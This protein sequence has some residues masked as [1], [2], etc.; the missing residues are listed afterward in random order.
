MKNLTPQSIDRLGGLARAKKLSAKQ[1]S[2]RL[3]AKA[4]GSR[5]SNNGYS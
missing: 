5:H 4:E 1:R 2:E 3:P